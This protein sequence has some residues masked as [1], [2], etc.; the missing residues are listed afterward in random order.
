MCGADDPPRS[1]G[2]AFPLRRRAFPTKEGERAVS[3]GIRAY[4]TKGGGSGAVDGGDD[5]LE[6][7]GHDVRVEPDP[8]QDLVAD[9]ALDVRRGDRVPARGQRMLVVVEDPDVIAV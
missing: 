3:T 7:G 9:G 2:R 4:S 6:G 1:G 8:P 5:R